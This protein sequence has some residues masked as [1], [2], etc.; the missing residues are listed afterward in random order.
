[1]SSAKRV[2][3]PPTPY[4][5]CHTSAIVEAPWHIFDTISLDNPRERH[6]AELTG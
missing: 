2:K 3:R 4:H 6:G 1:M 5:A